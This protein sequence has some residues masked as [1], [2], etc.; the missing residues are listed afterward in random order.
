VHHDEGSTSSTGCRSLKAGHQT[1]RRTIV[2]HGSGGGSGGPLNASGNDM[3]LE[4]ADLP[5]P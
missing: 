2:A 3:K 1:P 5:S 4:L